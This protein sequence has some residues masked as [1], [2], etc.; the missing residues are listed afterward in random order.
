MPMAELDS[1]AAT[2]KQPDDIASVALVPVLAPARWMPAR[3]GLARPDPAFVTHL[4]AMAA[5]M[6]QTR[7]LR[8][9]APSEAQLAY[10]SAANQNL[11]VTAGMAMR[12]IA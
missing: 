6:P 3:H 1:V 2:Q 4:I 11:S 8:R 7:L 9:A 12:Q 10:R 5:L